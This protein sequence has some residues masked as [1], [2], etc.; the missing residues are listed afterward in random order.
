VRISPVEQQFVLLHRPDFMDCGL[1]VFT[2]QS[3]IKTCFDGHISSLIALSTDCLRSTFYPVPSYHTKMA[4]LTIGLL[5]FAEF[6]LL[7]MAGPMECLNALSVH[8]GKH[9]HLHVIGKSMDPVGPGSKEKGCLSSFAGQQ[10]FMPTCTVHNAPPIDLLIV[11]GG[12]GS[13][14]KDEMQPFVDYIRRIASSPSSSVKYF[15]SVCTGAILFAWAGILDGQTATTNKAFWTQ[16]TSDG[17]KTHWI[18]K[19]R[20]VTSGRVWTTS[21][22]TAGIDGM[23]ALIAEVWDEETAEEVTA[24]IEHNRAKDPGEDPWAGKYGCEDILPVEKV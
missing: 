14:N 10:L 2:G 15:F 3:V 12:P 1:D 6:E 24:S 21:G 19:A 5:L 18:A 20:W 13:I 8:L 16:I 7:D 4:E 11:P 23:L 17:S 9:L 22:V